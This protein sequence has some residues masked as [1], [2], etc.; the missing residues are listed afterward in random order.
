MATAP[1]PRYLLLDALRG[2]A[3]IGV[4]LFHFGIIVHA[5]ILVAHGYFAVDFFFILSGFVIS[6][7]Y[8]ERMDSLGWNHFFKLRVKRLLPMSIFGVLLG[9]ARLLVQWHLHPELSDDLPHLLAGCG[10]NL[11]LIPKL[12]KGTASGRSMFPSNGALWS[13]LV[14]LII[15][16]AWAAWFIRWRNRALLITAGL[17]WLVFAG[18]AWHYGKSDI[19]WTY[20]GFVAAI[21]RATF[22]FLTGDLIWRFRSK[23]HLPPIAGWLL[24]ALLISMLCLP[25]CP[26]WVEVLVVLL[27]LPSLVYLAASVSTSELP[28]YRWLGD[29]SYPLYATHEPIVL[30]IASYAAWHS[31]AKVGLSSYLF[32]IPIVAFAYVAGKFYDAPIRS[33]LAKMAAQHGRNM[34]TPCSQSSIGLLSPVNL[35]A[36]S[37]QPTS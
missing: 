24:T 29:V 16:M 33:W 25:T 35:P 8:T 9:T 6:A 5:P 32:C 22:G 19:G 23:V 20:T 10:L 36:Q 30:A 37:V 2:G 26:W 34:Q 12:W 11:F 27:I 14:E 31:F 7:A 17:G 18:F 28:V 1:T 13:L 4:M 15:N 21:G 3:A